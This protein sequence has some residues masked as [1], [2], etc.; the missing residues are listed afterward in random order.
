MQIVVA[1]FLAILDF[2]F[3]SAC[4]QI[5][6]IAYL[7]SRLRIKWRLIQNHNGFFTRRKRINNFTIFFTTFDQGNHCA[8]TLGIFITS[9]I[10]F[11]LQLKLLGVIDFKRA[12]CSRTL[13]LGIHSLFVTLDIKGQFP[14]TGNIIGKINGKPIGIIEGKH[15][16]TG[17]NF[18]L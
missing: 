17:N 10:G 15:H 12:R 14:L 6:T 4:S 2:K 3:N 7:A 5:T 8:G 16:I 13:T 18:S 9:K 1:L 11:P